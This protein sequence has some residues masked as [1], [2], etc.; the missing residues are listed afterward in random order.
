LTLAYIYFLRL[1]ITKTVALYGVLLFAG[2]LLHTFYQSDLSFNTYF[3]VI[4]FLLGGILILDRKYEWVPIL[5]V[6]AA[7]NRET[8]ILIPFLLIAWGW[9]V[10]VDR[11]RALVCGAMALFI[12]ALI[13]VALRLYYPDAPMFRVGDELLPG[14]GLFR[15]NLTVPE[16]PVLLFQTFGFLP[17]LAPFTYRYWSPFVRMGFL[18]LVPVWILVHAF[19]SIWAET[20][21]FLVLLA[22]VFVPAILPVV[23]RRLQ[24]IRQTASFQKN[25][26]HRRGNDPD[27]LIVAM[28]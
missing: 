11:T 13:F 27:A 3:D 26:M 16:M 6:P 23:D 24:E 20:R 22:M 5:M 1:G 14:W 28:E 2:G 25:Q 10:S 17:L 19:S 18:L 8:S 7:L 9:R 15:Y 21:L 4:F 12:W